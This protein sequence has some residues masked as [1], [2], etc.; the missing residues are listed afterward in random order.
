MKEK[1][2]E[3]MKK[4]NFYN[5]GYCRYKEKCH[6]KHP[7][8]DCCE[9]S[10]RNKRCENRHPRQCKFEVLGKKCRHGDA[11]AFKHLQNKDECSEIHKKVEEQKKVLKAKDDQIKKKDDEIH[12]LKT[13]IEHLKIEKEKEIVILKTRI[14][15]VEKEIRRKDLRISKIEIRG[16]EKKLECEKCDFKSKNKAGLSRHTKTKHKEIE[17]LVCTVCEFKAKSTETLEEHQKDNE[18]KKY[19]IMNDDE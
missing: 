2:S 19:K 9:T 16:E 14:N 8:S 17:T 18:Y 12:N 10:C 13:N 4:C 1:I 7:K 6:F 5:V 15:E 11:C 3:I